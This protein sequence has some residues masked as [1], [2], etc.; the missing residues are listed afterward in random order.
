MACLSLSVFGLKYS[1]QMDPSVKSQIVLIVTY[2][3]VF[4]TLWL[5]FTA[6]QWSCVVI[7]KQVQ[8]CI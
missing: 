8:V 6:T 7:Q 1:L 3:S 2:L 5:V 4:T